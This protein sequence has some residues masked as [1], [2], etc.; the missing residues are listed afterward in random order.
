MWV[1]GVKTCWKFGVL[2]VDSLLQIYNTLVGFIKLNWGT[3][4][5]IAKIRHSRVS[6]LLAGPAP[7]LINQELTDVRM[8][9]ILNK[10]AIITNR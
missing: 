2:G 6:L 5:L 3:T 10:I 1:G 8:A 4:V 7:Q 9:R